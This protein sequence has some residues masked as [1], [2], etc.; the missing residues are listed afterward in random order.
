MGFSAFA[1]KH[2]AKADLRSSK[3]SVKQNVYGTDVV[4]SAATY[5]PKTG[6][7]V[8]VNRSEILEQSETMM[9][10]YDLQSNGFV[11]NRMYQLPNGSVAVTATI[12]SEYNQ[13]VSDRGTGY[14][15][16]SNGAWN[17]MP[18]TREEANATGADMRT[19]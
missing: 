6:Q 16:Y 2:V 10:T 19:G 18:T 13:T 11:S 14:N 3:V 7:S 12:S 4:N 5:S 9:T 17:D 15:F 8:V 1:Q